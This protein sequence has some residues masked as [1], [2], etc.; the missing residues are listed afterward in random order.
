VTDAVPA[1]QLFVPTERLPSADDHLP[2][3]AVGPLILRNCAQL[4]ERVAE[5]SAEGNPRLLVDLSEVP[6][7]DATG[8]GMLV[9]LVRRAKRGG[10][11]SCLHFVDQDG[12]IRRAV[13][14]IGLSRTMPIATS[15]SEALAS[16]E[17]S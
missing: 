13:A 12:N 4:R 3:V 9:G 1:L 6:L 10:A 17:G 2:L 7:I 16:H 5:L 14:K 11:D 8:L 15:W